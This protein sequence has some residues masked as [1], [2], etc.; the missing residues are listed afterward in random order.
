[1]GTA[2]FS[3]YLVTTNYL[4]V[5]MTSRRQSNHADLFCVQQTTASLSYLEVYGFSVD[6]A[7]L[8]NI[9]PLLGIW[10]AMLYCGIL[11]DRIVAREVSKHGSK[12]L[13]EKRLPVLIL[14]GILGVVGTAL[15][16]GCTQDHCHWMGAEIGSFGS[17]YPAH[18]FFC[19]L[20][21]HSAL[22]Q[23][24]ID[25]FGFVCANSIIYA[26][27]L[28]IYEARTDAVLVILNGTKNIAAFGI[29][30][31]VIP[32]NLTAGYTVPFVVMA[33]I[34][35]FA[36]L[37]IVVLFFKGTSIRAWS[38]KQFVS[39]RITHHGDAF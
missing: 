15:F 5:S 17:E 27:F 23:P 6:D 3:L 22:T 37:L 25:L 8:T 39:A 34:L 19:F 2:F 38:A 32:W 21:C 24:S 26:Y 33:A 30:Y 13:P 11:S 35:V 29:T 28:D 9:A 36:H 7:G 20:L 10:A 14:S 31:A 18:T 1:M 4:L 16:G 12:H